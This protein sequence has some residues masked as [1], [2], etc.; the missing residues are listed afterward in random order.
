MPKSLFRSS[1]GVRQTGPGTPR[2]PVK[3]QRVP[4][5]TRQT[6]NGHPVDLVAHLRW[7]NQTYGLGAR[8]LADVVGIN[9]NTVRNLLAYTTH[10][11]VDAAP[12]PETLTVVQQ[13]QINAI[14][15]PARTGGKA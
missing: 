11:R 13:Q 6:H 5:C 7:L 2:K 1:V 8:K 10:I 3:P 4:G 12:H 9:E 15:G 14:L